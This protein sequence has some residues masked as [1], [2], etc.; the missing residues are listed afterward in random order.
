MQIF[1]KNSKNIKNYSEF[2]SNTKNYGN[3]HYNDLYAILFPDNDDAV[4]EANG[5]NAYNQLAKL[6]KNVDEYTTDDIESFD[7]LKTI[8][9]SDE[10]NLGK[11]NKIFKTISSNDLYKTGLFDKVKTWLKKPGVVSKF[12]KFFTK[13]RTNG[14]EEVGVEEVEIKISENKG[15]GKHYSRGRKSRHR[16]KKTRKLRKQKKSRRA[17]KK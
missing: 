2:V 7:D 3:F 5:E 11:D 6:P 4:H 15:G 13:T 14:V 9:E 17:N 10:K 12:K 1:S 16:N 8:I